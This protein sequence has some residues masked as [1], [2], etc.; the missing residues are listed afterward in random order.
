MTDTL[1][2]MTEEKVANGAVVTN[3]TYS[4]DCAE[5]APTSGAAI[6]TTVLSD[7]RFTLTKSDAPDPVAAGSTITYTLGYQ[8]VGTN[9][10]TGVVVSDA[11]PANTTFVSATAGGTWCWPAARR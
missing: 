5:T 7:P 10:A 1:E 8:N 2:R 3:G 6:T 9:N 4:I 11:L